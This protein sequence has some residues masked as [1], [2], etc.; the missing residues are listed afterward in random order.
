MWSVKPVYRPASNCCFAVSRFVLDSRIVME[1]VSLS[2]WVEVWSNRMRE[3]QK[4]EPLIAVT[5]SEQ[6]YIFDLPHLLSLPEGFQ[7]RFR[8]R[9]KWVASDLLARIE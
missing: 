3:V 1:E 7:S 9:P 6:P 2:H 4:E 5:G 8:Y